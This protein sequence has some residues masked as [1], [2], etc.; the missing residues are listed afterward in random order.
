MGTHVPSLLDEQTQS[1]LCRR[2]WIP[3]IPILST[4]FPG[5]VCCGCDVGFGR[6]KL[7][8]HS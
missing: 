1:T 7:L 8:N 3:E 4:R 6:R 5:I 2:S